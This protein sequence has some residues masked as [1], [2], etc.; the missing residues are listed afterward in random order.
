[1]STRNTGELGIHL[2][3]DSSVWVLTK[4]TRKSKVSWCP[5]FPWVQLT[6]GVA[7]DCTGFLRLLLA[8]E[9]GFWSQDG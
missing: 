4:G 7:S 3:L 6:M 5:L 1:M 9:I 2:E 8:G